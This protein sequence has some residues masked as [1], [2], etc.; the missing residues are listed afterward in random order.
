MTRFEHYK[1]GQVFGIRYWFDLKG[2]RIPRHSHDPTHAHNIVVIRGSIWVATEEQSR[3]CTQGVHDIDWAAPHEVIA[4][5]E[6]TE[7]FHLFLNG[8][9]AGYETLTPEDLRGTL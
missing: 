6:D 1:S 9:P 2:D 5:V 4:A 3:L 7:V 8:Q